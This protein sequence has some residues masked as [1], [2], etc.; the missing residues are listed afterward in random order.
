MA[1]RIAIPSA[2]AMTGIVPTATRRFGV[3]FGI[4][5]PA[6]MPAASTVI[7][8]VLVAAAG[9]ISAPTAVAAIVVIVVG[10]TAAFV[11]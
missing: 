4:A 7:V 6:T 5:E 3:P 11:T 9:S 1:A 10:E 2:L 8:V